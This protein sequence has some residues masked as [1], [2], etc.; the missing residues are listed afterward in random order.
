MVRLQKR[1]ANDDIHYASMWCYMPSRRI[2]VNKRS[3][4]YRWNDETAELRNACF[5]TRGISQRS[6]GTPNIGE[7][8]KVYAN[9]WGRLKLRT[10]KRECFQKLVISGMFPM[11]I[12]ASEVCGECIF[13]K[14]KQN[15]EVWQSGSNSELDCQVP[16]RSTVWFPVLSSGFGDDTVRLTITFPNFC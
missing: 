4:S 11:V 14:R 12:V 16:A 15:T 2:L 13:L 8:L 1:G 7:K 5:R 10:M 9:L 3:N 6:R